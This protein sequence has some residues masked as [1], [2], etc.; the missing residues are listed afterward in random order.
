MKITK[1]AS[2]QAQRRGIKQEL[3]ELVVAYGD[4]FKGRQHARIYRVSRKEAQ[5]IK[6]ECPPMLWRRYRD[7]LH[8]VASV[9]AP[10]D[11]TLITTMHRHRPMWKRL[12]RE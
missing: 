4:E 12:S 3:L 7:R 2:R 8:S 11:D 6:A 1:H 9:V 5:F 10:S